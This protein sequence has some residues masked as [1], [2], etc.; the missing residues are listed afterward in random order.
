M[1]LGNYKVK[2]QT[3]DTQTWGGACAW[4]GGG[5]IDYRMHSFTNFFFLVFKS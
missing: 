2:G 4:G 5:G 1:L 3:Y